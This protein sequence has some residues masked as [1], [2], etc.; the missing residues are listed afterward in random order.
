MDGN[1]VK[2]IPLNSNDVVSHYGLTVTVIF[3]SLLRSP[4]PK[5]RDNTQSIFVAPFLFQNFG[6]TDVDFKLWG[7]YLLQI[8]ARIRHLLCVTGKSDPQ[9]PFSR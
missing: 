9:V 1:P 2:S 4:A 5:M 3:P 6:L 8:D 7:P